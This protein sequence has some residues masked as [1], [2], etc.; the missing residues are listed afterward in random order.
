L[1]REGFQVVAI[2]KTVDNDVFGTDFCIGF[3]TAVTRSVDAIHALRTTTDSHERIGVVELFGR[4]SG[5]TS[6]FAAYLADV[7]RAVIPQA[8]FDM[9]RFSRFL[10]EDRSKNPSN[11]AIMTISEGAFVKGGTI[12]ETR[13]VDAYGHRKLGGT[14]CSWQKRLSGVQA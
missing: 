4:N 14:V 5:E 1:R 2:P 7:D 8:P 9:D 13:E 12:F 3:S 11:Y 10:I 6:L